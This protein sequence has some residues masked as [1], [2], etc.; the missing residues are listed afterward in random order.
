VDA[1]SHPLPEHRV[2]S[3]GARERTQGAE[4][5]CSPIRGTTILT[6][7]YF[8]ELPGIKPQIKEYTWLN[9]WIQLYM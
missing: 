3:E 2:S 8:P 9:S 7:K 5:V 1:H 4:G 6:N